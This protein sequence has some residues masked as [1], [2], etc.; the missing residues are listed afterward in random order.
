MLL[1]FIV[2]SPAAFLSRRRGQLLKAILL[3]RNT[4]SKVKRNYYPDGRSCRKLLRPASAG[5]INRKQT[6][7]RP[8]IAVFS[9]DTGRKLQS[10]TLTIQTATSAV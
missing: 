10:A 3:L 6:D 4:D 7:T 5:V 2:Q 8:L 9:S 1:V